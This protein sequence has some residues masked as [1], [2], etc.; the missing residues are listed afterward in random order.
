MARHK[1]AGRFRTRGELIHRIKFLWC[2]TSCNMSQIARNCGISVPTV[3]TIISE[4]EWE[5]TDDEFT[6]MVGDDLRDEL[7]LSE[8]PVIDHRDFFEPAEKLGVYD[9]NACGAGW[10]PPNYPVHLPPSILYELEM[11]E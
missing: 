1:T 4:R 3:S 9:L 2:Y 6:L 5:K 7:D 10:M 11:M 8:S